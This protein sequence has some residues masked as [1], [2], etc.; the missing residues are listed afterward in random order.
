MFRGSISTHHQDLITLYL[1]HLALMRPLLLPVMKVATS[2]TGSSVMSSDDG[3]KYHPKHVEQLTDINKLYTG[4]SCWIIIAIYYTM[5]GPLN[6]KF[7]ILFLC[8]VYNKCSSD[9]F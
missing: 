2:T 7:L 1:Q 8:R 4:A 5:H 3:W 9:F 6:I